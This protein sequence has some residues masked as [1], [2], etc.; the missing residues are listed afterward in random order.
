LS[1]FLKD[2]LRTNRRSALLA[3]WMAVVPLTVSS[4]VAVLALRYE[5]QIQAFAPPEWALY[6]LL[7]CLTMALALTPTTFIALLSGFFLGMVSSFFVIP[8]YLAASFLGYQLTRLIDNGH[9]LQTIRGLPGGRGEKAL[10]LLEGIRQNQLGLIIMA[11]I[12]PVLP[13]ALMNVMLPIAGVRLREFLLA[14]TAGMLPRTLFFIWLGGQA[15][16]LQTLIEEGGEGSLSQVMFI[17]LLAVSV[18]GLLYY[19]RRILKKY[20]EP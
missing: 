11:R 3:L 18:M 14:G 17:L 9:F 19:A 10:R 8:A 5:N 16:E 12:S 6:F 13:F 2:L 20:V 1:N 7:S 15:Q 4:L